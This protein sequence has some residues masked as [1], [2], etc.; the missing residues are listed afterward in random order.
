MIQMRGHT[1]CARSSRAWALA[2]VGSE[3]A[4]HSS[5]LIQAQVGVLLISL[6]ASLFA[7]SSIA[8]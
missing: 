6:A 2:R 5:L 3:R 8:L 7:V 1:S 4:P